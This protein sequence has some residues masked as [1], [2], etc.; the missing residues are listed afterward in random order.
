MLPAHAADISEI[1]AFMPLAALT[2][3]SSL[4]GRLRDGLH[5]RAEGGGAARRDRDAPQAH[6]VEGTRRAGAAPAVATATAARTGRRT[7]SRT[8]KAS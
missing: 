1:L 4:L 3:L 7:P 5:A 2:E 6:A 8:R